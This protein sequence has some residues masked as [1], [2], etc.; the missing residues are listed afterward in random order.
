MAAFAR[1]CRI[2]AAPVLLVVLLGPGASSAAKNAKAAKTVAPRAAAAP[3]AAWPESGPLEGC[4]A[5]LV[6][7]GLVDPWPESKAVRPGETI[8]STDK[9]LGCRFTV[10]GQAGERLLVEARLTRPTV[11][12]G[13]PAVDRWYV[14]ARRNEPTSATYAFFPPGN[15][16]PGT[17]RLE[18]FAGDTLL[19]AATFVAPSPTGE[20]GPDEKAASA[21][22]APPALP[23]AG[24]AEAPAP[25]GRVAKTSDL[26]AAATPTQ[27]PI[28]AATPV[29]ASALAA[30]SGQAPT[31][32]TSPA[33]V[34]AMAGVPG[35]A[36]AVAGNS[37]QAPAETGIRAAGGGTAPSPRPSGSASPQLPADT[38]AQTPASAAASVPLAV[39][40]AAPASVAA[41]ES[42]QAMASAQA[43]APGPS[44]ATAPAPAAAPAKIPATV[45]DKVQPTAPAQVATPGPASAQSAAVS[46]PAP[47]RVSVKTTA[48]AKAA[49]AP[50]RESATAKLPAK[51]FIALQTGLFADAQN[52]ANQAAL[53][54]A[55][56]IPAC[57]AEEK[58]GGKARHRV[59]AG[60]FGDKRA[61]Q[62]GRGEVRAAVGLSPLVYAVEPAQAA[63]LR[64]H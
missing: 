12:G 40:A 15:V 52:A 61:A 17:W 51:G 49:A 11:P 45:P 50:A 42:T 25:P 19:G 33:Q 3:E 6:E 23:S 32:T 34:P 64:C 55:K 18:L 36:A 21:G 35:Q 47:A 24:L 4:G 14:P 9:G 1:L 60:H 48:K 5:L 31:V 26:A 59:L 22:A 58:Q 2:V 43:A 63:G 16:A 39:N 46:P 10:P 13:E 37:A 28:P 27:P 7:P 54:R 56:G 57:V 8:L 62:L 38:A 41:P 29:E 53:L 44:Q 20:T 30:A